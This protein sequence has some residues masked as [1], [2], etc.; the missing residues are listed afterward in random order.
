[1]TDLYTRIIG[2]EAGAEDQIRSPGRYGDA[3]FGI[4]RL[5]GVMVFES[6]SGWIFRITEAPLFMIS[7]QNL[8]YLGGLI[9]MIAAN[10]T[11]N[12]IEGRA[13]TDPALS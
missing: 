1:M 12:I 2:A 9:T 3:C 4:R 5:E 11:L 10:I 8:N 6:Y 7:S 13:I